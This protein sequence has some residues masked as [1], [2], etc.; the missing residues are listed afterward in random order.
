MSNV[1]V[2]N[3]SLMPL[4]ICDWYRAV[5][6][7]VR[8]RAEVLESGDKLL[9]GNFPLPLVVRLRNQVNVPY[10]PLTPNRSNILARD[11][12]TCQYCSKKHWDLTLDHIMPSSRGG[13][14]TWENLVAACYRCNSKKGDRTP[15]E[16]GMKLLSTPLRPQDRISFMLMKQHLSDEERRTW[17]PYLKR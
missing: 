8:G 16:A 10:S 14:S 6:M 11:R 4:N 15:S 9:S 5:S 17:A 7:I 13:K 12:Y 3:Q 1:L 2:L